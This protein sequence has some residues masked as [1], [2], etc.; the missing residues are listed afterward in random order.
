M[1][2]SPSSVRRRLTGLLLGL[3]VMLAGC[4]AGPV[5]DL[6]PPG[7][8]AMPP[9]QPAAPAPAGGDGAPPPPA[10][11]GGPFEG[12]DGF[13]VPPTQA[14]AWVEANAGD[15]RA[16]VI[17]ERIAEVPSSVWLTGGGVGSAVDDVVSAAAAEGTVPV[18]VAYNV[19][20]RDCGQF[21]SGGADGGDAYRAWID[22]FASAI[23]DRPAIV[24]LEPD[25]LAGLDCLSD[26][27]RQDRMDLL[28]YAVEQLAAAA[29]NAWTYLDAGHA[30]WQPAGVIAERL[31]AAGVASARGFALNV[32]NYHT[33]ADN[34]AYGD[35]VNA[36]LGSAQPFVVDTSRNG[37]GSD[38]EW[39]N[40]PG[41][42]IGVAPN[43]HE[44]GSGLEMELWVK[45]PGES[46]GS[47][48]IGAGTAA[49]QFVPDI[50]FE[51]AGG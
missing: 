21:S 42:A 1:R 45:L 29:P 31:A 5:F 9:Q 15:P 19:P 34:A 44:P 3:V 10:T 35:A 27:N 25:A 30:G 6:D 4:D 38:G 46:D 33:T 51:L 39:C 13:Y 37:N 26:A 28:R 41:R 18:L 17:R 11:A 8:A 50:A 22:E 23:G 14:A 49:G 24:V 43:V 40:P 32:S 16:D 12:T 20:G 36:A 7:E 47:C 48:G 2:G